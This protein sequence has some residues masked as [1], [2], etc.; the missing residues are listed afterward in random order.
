MPNY[1]PAHPIGPVT[2]AADPSGGA[3]KQ[4]ELVS[5]HGGILVFLQVASKTIKSS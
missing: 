3:V 2:R 4:A 1:Q 5:L